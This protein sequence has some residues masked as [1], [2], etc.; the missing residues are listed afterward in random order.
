MRSLILISIMALPST[1]VYSQTAAAE[2]KTQ[3]SFP[4]LRASEF[5]KLLSLQEGAKANYSSE[6]SNVEFSKGVS[7]KNNFFLQGTGVVGTT[8]NLNDLFNQNVLPAASIALSGHFII[9]KFGLS[10]Y[11]YDATFK[12]NYSKLKNDSINLD[13]ISTKIDPTDKQ[14]FQYKP[15][16]RKKV[17]GGS[18]SKDEELYTYKRIIWVTG[19]GKYENVK[20]QFYDTS[21]AF[22]KQLYEPMYSTFNIKFLLNGY[23]YWNKSDITWSQ[24]KFNRR[25]NFIYWNIGFQIGLG[26]NVQQLKKSTINDITAI[27]VNGTTT[28]QVGKTQT[29][30]TGI[31]KEFTS[32]VPSFEFIYSPFRL[33]AIDIF[34]DYTAINKNDKQKYKM[35]DF[36]S[37]AGGLY[38]YSDEK[39]SKINIGVYYK[40]TRNNST[41]IWI[42]QIGIKASIPITP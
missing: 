24:G 8:S 34:G 7:V 36:Y 18:I 3:A 5:T 21:R 19:T 41:N 20:Y 12:R 31:Y 1:I 38:F 26:N 32:Y 40:K 11:F 4:E 6:K 13:D 33:I 23:H 30:Y 29:A 2:K 28:R 9:D 37:I 27:T 14:Q 35:E 17:Q 42:D 15:A 22:A 25:P 39:T 16:L 10:K